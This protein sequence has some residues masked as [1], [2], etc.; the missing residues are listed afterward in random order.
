[1]VYLTDGTCYNERIVTDGYACVYKYHRHNSK[2]LS[3][4]I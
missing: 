4:E 2:Q 3:W 1:M